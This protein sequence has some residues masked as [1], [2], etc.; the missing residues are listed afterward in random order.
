MVSVPASRPSMSTLRPSAPQL[1]GF[2][3]CPSCRATHATVTH[4]AVGKGADWHC[5][6]CGQQ[7]SATR[8]AAV[9]AYADWVSGQTMPLDAT[10]ERTIDLAK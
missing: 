10:H 3:T 4:E 6:R 5:A 1:V 9:A 2:A 7:W 8:V